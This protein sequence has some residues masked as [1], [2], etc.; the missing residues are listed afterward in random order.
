MS[1]LRSQPWFP[2][3]FGLGRTWA[4][5]LACSTFWALGEKEGVRVLL[6]GT[7]LATA[8]AD[9]AN[10][11]STFQILRKRNDGGNLPRVRAL[12]AA[13]IDGRDHIEICLNRP[14]RAIRI[15]APFYQRCI[16]FCVRPSR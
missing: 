9:T 3:S 1:R 10:F 16:Q 12:D 6:A 4:L 13:R 11:S 15:S 7:G 8:T 5:L 14:N 2:S